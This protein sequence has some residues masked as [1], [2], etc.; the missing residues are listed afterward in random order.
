LCAL[1]LGHAAAADLMALI[2]EQPGY[3]EIQKAVRKAGGLHDPIVVSHDGLVIEGNTRTAAVKTLHAG[4]PSDAR[5]HSIPV[6]RLPKTVPERSIAMLMASYHVAGKTVWRPYA[7]ADQMV[8]LRTLHGWTV[9]QIADETR[10]SSKRVQQHLEAYAYLVEE[11]LPKV[12]NGGESQL[13]ES[14]FS[15]ALEF[16]TRKNLA[17]I[18]GDPNVR[19]NLAQLLVDNKIKG[20]EVKELDKVMKHR[21][22]SNA[23]KKDGFGAAKTV[24]SET[25]PLAGSKVLKEVQAVTRL[26]S[27]MGQTDIALLKKSSPARKV[28]LQLDDAIR[29]VATIVGMK[30]STNDV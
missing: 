20:A 17:A 25:D 18:R 5:W 15:H 8:Q 23:L 1:Q 12:R 9:E 2:K 4:N 14:R 26:L 11:V 30:L 27:K 13:L 7:Q 22:A 3:D 24:L 19:R 6:A 10:M 16:V 28:I 29:S 21:K